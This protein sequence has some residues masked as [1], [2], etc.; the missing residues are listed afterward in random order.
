MATSPMY[1]VPEKWGKTAGCLVY[2][3]DVG[4]TGIGVIYI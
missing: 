2:K 3:G 1:V 4:V